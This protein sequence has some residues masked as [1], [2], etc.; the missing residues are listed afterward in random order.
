MSLLPVEERQDLER[1]LAGIGRIVGLEKVRFHVMA[2][3]DLEVNRR[4]E[5]AVFR[6]NMRL[7]QPL[8]GDLESARKTKEILL[9]SNLPPETVRW[10]AVDKSTVEVRTDFIPSTV[11]LDLIMRLVLWGMSEFFVFEWGGRNVV[12]LEGG[13]FLIRDGSKVLLKSFERR[14]LKVK[15]KLE[16][17][18][19]ERYWS[20]KGG[21]VLKRLKVYRPQLYQQSRPHPSCCRF[22][23]V[24]GIN[25]SLQMIAGP[26]VTEQHK[27]IV[28]CGGTAAG[29]VPSAYW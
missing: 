12:D 20:R 13:L 14:R 25:L 15:G 4:S 21:R 3:S 19:L 11:D 22:Q 24:D 28:L 17:P 6:L 27:G 18:T 5:T 16:G 8:E 10:R 1:V 7:R 23:C 9:E 29:T 26:L 2:D